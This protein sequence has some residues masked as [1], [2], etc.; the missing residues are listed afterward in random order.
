MGISY[1]YLSA[2]QKKQ[3]KAE[4]E[5]AAQGVTQAGESYFGSTPKFVDR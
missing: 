1:D 5:L 2:I 4:T 3:L